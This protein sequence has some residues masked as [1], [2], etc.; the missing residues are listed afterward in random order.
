MKLSK[1]TIH[2]FRGI[3]EIDINFNK[4]INYLVA[5][6]NVGKT[7]IIE[8]ID[9]FYDVTNKE[10]IHVDFYY[11]LSSR[12][13]DYLNERLE[14]QENFENYICIT[15][16]N[17]RYRCGNFEFKDLIKEGFFGEVIYIPAVSD[18]S[19]I[20]DVSKTTTYISKAISSLIEK[21]VRLDENLEKLNRDLKEYI[22]SLQNESK[23]LISKMNEDILFDNVELSIDNKVFD[24]SQIIKN[25][26]KL[27]AK[28]NGVDRDI[29]TLGTGVQRSIVNSIIAN[30]IND[31]KFTIILYDEPETFLNV[32]LQRKLIQGININKNNNQY[33]I[34]THSPDIIYRS[35]NIIQ[36]IIKIKKFNKT[37]KV[38][39]FDNDKYTDLIRQA[40]DEL[41]SYGLEEKYWLKTNIN[42]TILA[43]WDRNRVNALF[44]DK[45]LLVEGPTE[46]IFIDMICTDNIISYISTASGKFSMPYFKIL[47]EDIFDIKT[48]T[49]YDKD[50]ENKTN[51][52]AINTYISR[53]FENSLCLNNCLE[54]ELGYTF[55]S[56]E[57]PRKPQIF[58]EKY[59][60]REI[61]ERVNGLKQRIYDLFL[62]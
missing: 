32:G 57:K 22:D 41:K 6:N 31:E 53:N 62:I 14:P 15:L 43:W 34:A 2:K 37:L 46:E 7:R 33:V 52:R 18:H 8:C 39:Q 42:Q 20:T 38:F 49:M 27:S 47:F 13:T 26:I 23:N 9:T 61:D 59:F 56:S 55:N 12:E 1:I 29:L 58:L 4:F 30:G 28:E 54:D 16:E 35:E 21:N 36:S 45:V 48:R 51:H 24:N 25:N 11:S 44:E 50:D 19:N 17:R 10:D 5:N 40:N 3:N 60:N